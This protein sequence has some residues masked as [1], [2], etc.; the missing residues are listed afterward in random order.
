MPYIIQSLLMYY[1]LMVQ[2]YVDNI[3]YIIIIV[4]RPMIQS[5]SNT[6]TYIFCFTSTSN[7]I[8]THPFSNTLSLNAEVISYCLKYTSPLWH[9]QY[10]VLLFNLRVVFSQL[11]AGMENGDDGESLN[12]QKASPMSMLRKLCLITTI[13]RW[14]HLD[15]SVISPVL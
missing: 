13:A 11:K 6:Y 5:L 4:K 12:S 3:A 8:S 14:I 1:D 2:K 15:Q 7:C 10:K 9:L